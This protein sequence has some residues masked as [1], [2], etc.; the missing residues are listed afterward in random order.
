M[1][2]RELTTPLFETLAGQ[3]EVERKSKQQG[4]PWLVDI[5]KNP[6]LQ[7]LNREMNMR[8]YGD[9][10]AFLIGRDMYAWNTTDALHAE[11]AEK[12]LKGKDVKTTIPIVFVL[13]GRQAYAMVT[14]FSK[15]TI[16]NH[17]PAVATAISN[18]PHIRKLADR[19]EVDYYDE[20]IG[21][22]WEQAY[23]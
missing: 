17:N 13:D 3:M 15:R 18:H 22:S 14:D 1:Q 10:R 16:W 11:V 6:T 7:E 2:V 5:W 20:A 21:G 23:A 19:V 12:F 4:F 9:V 8:K